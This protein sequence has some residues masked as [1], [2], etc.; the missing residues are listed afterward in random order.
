MP[1]RTNSAAPNPITKTDR[2]RNRTDAERSFIQNA[3][4]NL[5]Q[6][7]WSITESDDTLARQ[8]FAGRKHAGSGDRSSRIFGIASVRPIAGGRLVGARAGQFYYRP[9]GKS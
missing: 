1:A 2:R 6:H 8:N 9:Q 7:R 3:N 4:G 5:Q